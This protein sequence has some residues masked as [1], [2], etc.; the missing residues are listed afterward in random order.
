MNDTH[1]RP[2]TPQVLTQADFP[3]PQSFE[4]PFPDRRDV[5]DDLVDAYYGALRRPARTVY[6]LDT[7][8]SMAD[9][10]RLDALKQALTDLTRVNQNSSAAFQTREQVTFI[11]FGSNVSTPSTFDIPPEQ[12]RPVLDQIG[13]Y[14]T[15]LRVTGET[16][17]YD[18][19]IEAYRTVDRLSTQDTDRITTIVLLTDGEWNKGSAPEAF[20][21][22]RQSL[23]PDV[24]AVPVFP[25]R[26]GDNSN[27]AMDQ[28]ATLTGGQVFD[29]RALPLST[30]FPLIRG[31]Q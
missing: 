27:A 29:G 4:L 8:G 25:I 12:P 9:F 15:N 20:A 18:A 17:L 5:I 14:V 2:I 7:S 30:L 28:I 1:R 26:Y 19:L 13:A 22:F 24:S 11:S 31:S 6:V 3:A 16:A 10:G 23:R 21:A